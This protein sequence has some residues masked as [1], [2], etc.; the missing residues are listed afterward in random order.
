MNQFHSNYFPSYTETLSNTP[1]S[2]T[3]HAKSIHTPNSPKKFSTKISIDNTL[4]TNYKSS[5]NP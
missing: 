4:I 5:T 2:S 3:K 1:N